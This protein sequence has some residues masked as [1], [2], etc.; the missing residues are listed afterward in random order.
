MLAQRNYQPTFFA[1]FQSHNRGITSRAWATNPFLHLR[2]ILSR[3]VKDYTFNGPTSNEPLFQW[4]LQNKIV[5]ILNGFFIN[6]RAQKKTIISLIKHFCW[7]KLNTFILKAI[8][9]TRM[10]KFSKKNIKYIKH[11]QQPSASNSPKFTIKSV[12]NSANR[13][14][15]RENFYVL[16]K[17]Q[18]SLRD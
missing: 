13:K 2:Q 14:T 1:F 10:D 6:L 15:I 18:L 11:W 17:N 3:I 4:N 5:N 9:N 12:K 7:M 16:C 8:N